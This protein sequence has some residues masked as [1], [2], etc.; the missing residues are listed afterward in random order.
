MAEIV[1]VEQ[2]RE[3]LGVDADRDNEITMLRS[4]A[5]EHLCRATGIDWKARQDVETF[6]EAVRTQ[7]WMSYY[8]IRDEAKNTQFLREYLTSLICSLQLCG[9]DSETAGSELS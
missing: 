3:F 4:S 9:I 6:N 8:A 2:L 1:S 5:I 7:V